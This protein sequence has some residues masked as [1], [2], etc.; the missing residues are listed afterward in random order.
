MGA[1]NFQDD[2]RGASPTKPRPCA[3]PPDVRSAPMKSSPT[4]GEHQT[5]PLSADGGNFSGSK[6]DHI[7]MERAITGCPETGTQDGETAL[8]APVAVDHTAKIATSGE[9]VDVFA[10]LKHQHYRN[11]PSVEWHSD[12]EEAPHTGAIGVN[13]PQ[14]FLARRREGQVGATTVKL[15]F[16]LRVDASIDSYPRRPH[17][18]DIEVDIGDRQEEF[19]ILMDEG[20]VQP[21]FGVLSNTTFDPVLACHLHPYDHSLHIQQDDLV[22]EDNSLVDLVMED[23]GTEDEKAMASVTTTG[24]LQPFSWIP[25]SASSAFHALFIGVPTAQTAGLV[26]GSTHVMESP[27]LGNPYAVDMTNF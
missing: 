18:L 9:G 16:G 3:S 22:G 1:F 20:E 10:K 8:S 12:E 17:D 13:V 6:V 15:P 27:M 11:A 4:T 25:P 5:L 21:S 26:D 2:G 19:S 7:E 24:S 23:T 14:S